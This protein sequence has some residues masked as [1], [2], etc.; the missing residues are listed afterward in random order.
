MRIKVIDNATLT[1]YLLRP[2]NINITGISMEQDIKIRL[3]NIY[4]NKLK[5]LATLE[6]YSLEK[7]TEIIVMKYLDSLKID[8][9]IGKL[10]RPKSKLEA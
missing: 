6:S 9:M 3:D 4:H 8:G 10:D 5:E 7:T 2:Y 1:L